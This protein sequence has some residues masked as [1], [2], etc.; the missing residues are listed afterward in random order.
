M[1]VIAEG[2]F[3]YTKA[4]CSAKRTAKHSIHAPAGGAIVCA[5]PVSIQRKKEEA[6]LPRVLFRSRGNQLS[7]ELQHMNM[8]V[9]WNFAG[10][11]PLGMRVG[12]STVPPRP[13]QAAA[14]QA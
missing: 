11:Y 3:L 2:A 8:R 14:V 1:G 5:G 4:R 10:R 9:W 6:P 7:P 12:L 13:F